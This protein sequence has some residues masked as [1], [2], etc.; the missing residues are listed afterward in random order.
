MT[1]TIA[2][3]DWIFLV[4]LLL[5]CLLGMS[6]GLIYE[7][8]ILAGWIA[9]YFVARGAGPLTGSWLPLGGDASATLR[10]GLGGTL[11]FIVVAFMWSG[12][13]WRVSR[14]ARMAGLR[15]VDGMLGAAFGAARGLVV[16]LVVTAL[17]K[18]T[19]LAH[20][21]W[22][23]ASVGARWLEITLRQIY[24]YLPPQAVRYLSA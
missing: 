10:A 18:L 21:A 9:A 4:V 1:A 23:N 22:W 13:A 15:P 11:V 2:P 24:P 14:T 8:L 20:A 16:L 17:V 19:P 5:S 3:L 12:I 6:R 7:A